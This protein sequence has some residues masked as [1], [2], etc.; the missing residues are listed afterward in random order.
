[1]TTLSIIN[2]D[3]LS[4]FHHKYFVISAEV[5]D[6]LVFK[7]L[8]RKEDNYFPFGIL[9]EVYPEA[10]QQALANVY[11]AELDLRISEGLDDFLFVYSKDTQDEIFD[12]VAAT[13]ILLG[14]EIRVLDN[15]TNVTDLT[16]SAG[17][18]SEAILD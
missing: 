5:D 6:T 11:K 17:Q 7:R 15:I 2:K 8:K 16:S 10:S 1:M 13:S 9:T 14:I 4:V 12:L 3:E 18:W